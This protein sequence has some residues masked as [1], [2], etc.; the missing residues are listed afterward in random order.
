MTDVGSQAAGAPTAD[1]RGGGDEILGLFTDRQQN[2][3][4]DAFAV[5]AGSRL[6]G[7]NDSIVIQSTYSGS[8]AV[9]DAYNVGGTAGALARVVGG[10][11]YISAGLWRD[12]VRRRLY[13]QS[14]G[15]VQG[16]DDRINGGPGDL[17]TTSHA[18]GDVS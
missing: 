14:N 16:G 9:G 13:P 10:N 15:S 4:G 3:A 1:Y 2:V 12:P 5:Y 11:D 18:V 17:A 8:S 7:G 6:T